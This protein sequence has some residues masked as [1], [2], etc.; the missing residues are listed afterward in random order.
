MGRRVRGIA[1]GAEAPRNH[2]TDQP[3][4]DHGAAL[5]AVQFAA[6]QL[7]GSCRHPVRD[8][9]RHPRA[10]PHRS[11]FQHLRRGR[12]RIAVRRVCDEWDSHHHLLQRSPSERCARRCGHAARGRATDAPDAD[13]GALRMHRLI[14]GRNLARHRRSGSATSGDG[15]RGRHAS[16]ADPV[17]GCR[18]GIANVVA[19]KGSGSGA[20]DASGSGH[21]FPRDGGA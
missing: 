14:S 7:S 1:S 10:L 17:A 2:R 3:R 15:D 16:W 13:D 5:R 9:R 21:I 4:A 6:R 12:L 19:R 18:A 8:C 11:R 20:L